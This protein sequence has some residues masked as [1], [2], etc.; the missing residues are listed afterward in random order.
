MLFL[1]SCI[2]QTPFI[3]E[4]R[5][6]ISTLDWSVTEF[7]GSEDASARLVGEAGIAATVAHGGTRVAGSELLER[8]LFDRL[9]VVDEVISRAM[10][11]V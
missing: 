11:G 3:R 2:I 8:W 9:S 1:D 5:T 6:Q 7:L 10:A 4:F